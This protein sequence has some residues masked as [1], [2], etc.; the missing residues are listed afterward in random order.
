M[1][2]ASNLLKLQQLSLLETYASI[3][4][5]FLRDLEYL[6]PTNQ[7]IGFKSYNLNILKREGVEAQ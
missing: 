1:A 4:Q 2:K 3:L 6:Q 5:G 7:I